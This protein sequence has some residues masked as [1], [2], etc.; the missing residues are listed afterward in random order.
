MHPLLVCL[1]GLGALLASPSDARAQAVVGEKGSLELSLTHSYG[2]ASRIEE[3]NGKT[4]PSV[5]VRTQTSIL[6]AEF[7]PIERLGLSVSIPLMGVIYDKEKS[8]ALYDPHGDFDDGSY[9][10]TLQDLRA[11]VR[12]MVLPSPLALSFNL[13]LTA[14]LQ[15]YP[16]RG[17]AAPGRH[18]FQGRIGTAVSWSPSFLPR[19][20]ISASYE[21]TLSQK[22]NESADTKEFSQTRSEVMGQLGY[23]V[24]PKLPVFL[25]TVFRQQHDGV[26]Y[27]DF[28]M[29][30]AQ[31]QLFHDPLLKE[32]I[33]LLGLGAAYQITDKIYVSATYH[34]FISGLNTLNTN[35]ASVGV[36]WN[37][38]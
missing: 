12:Y 16:V 11:D 30:T 13:G 15:D 14:P 4:F 25:S 28:A 17:S 19:S 2:F 32:R 38:R 20:F 23:F 3:S 35:I 24:T 34:H 33:L 36:G 18:L 1:V 26:E 37:A 8:G 6:S 27:V 7:V 10:F 21:L 22:V 9:H 5:F 29:L 31:Q